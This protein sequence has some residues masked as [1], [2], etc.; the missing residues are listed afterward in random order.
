MTPVVRLLGP[1]DAGLYAQLRSEMLID[2]PASFSSSPGEAR[3][4][5]REQVIEALSSDGH[6]IAGVFVDDDLVSVAGIFRERR[7][8]QHHRA[9]VY[10]VY[11]TPG[12]RGRGHGRAVMEC[13]LEAARAMVGVE[14]VG[15]GVS[16]NGPGA[17]RLYESLGFVQWGLEPDSMRVD[18]VS[19]G[20]VYLSL[21]L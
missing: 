5:T 4:E 11:T 20:E 3:G 12:A 13:V 1:A 19:Y 18:G 2:S 14:V 10:G 7:A 6:E 21:V 8:K 15:I 16:T 17:L 9:F